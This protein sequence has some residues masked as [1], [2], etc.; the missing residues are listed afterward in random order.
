LPA[1]VTARYEEA[2]GYANYWYNRQ[3]QQQLWDR[4]VKQSQIDQLPAGNWQLAGKLPSGESLQIFLGNARGSIRLPSDQS[5]AL[6]AG[7]LD[8]QLSPPGSGGLLVALHLWQ[9][10]LA[11]GLQQF[12]EMYYLGQLPTGPEGE[13][14]D[15]LVGLY[16]GVEF[17]L[18]FSPASGELV[19]L[20]LFASD[21]LDPCEVR[22][23]EYSTI[24]GVRLP[25]RW[26]VRCGDRVFAELL[27]DSWQVERS[28]TTTEEVR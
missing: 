11:K 19:G 12:G 16:G 24:D 1:A 15:C 6:F 18:L 28:S 4:Y 3:R 2:H 25:V 20:D 26:L 22:F 7:D 9:R 14:A 17:R 8:S 23:L 21:D 10:F 27:I 13:L 5:G